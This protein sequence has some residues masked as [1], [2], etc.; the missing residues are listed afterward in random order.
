MDP[1]ARN[2]HLTAHADEETRQRAQAVEPHEFLSKLTAIETALAGH[3][4]LAACR[5]GPGRDSVRQGRMD[6]K[7]PVRAWSRHAAGRWRATASLLLPISLT[8]IRSWSM[9][10]AP[11]VTRTRTRTRISKPITNY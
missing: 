3:P 10:D 11:F 7:S 9:T 6:R 1:S 4:D 5:H 8:R 2:R